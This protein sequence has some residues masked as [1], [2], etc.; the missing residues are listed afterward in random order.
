MD[1]LF[2]QL[3]ASPQLGRLN[4]RQN[5]LASLPGSLLAALLTRLTHCDLSQTGLL[6]AQAREMFTALADTPPSRLARLALNEVKNYFSFKS[7]KVILS[8]HT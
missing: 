1:S 2:E 4:V 3:A 7:F 6:P 8:K 5:S